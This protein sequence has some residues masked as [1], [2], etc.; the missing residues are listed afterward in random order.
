MKRRN[1]QFKGKAC[2]RGLARSSRAVWGSPSAAMQDR[3]PPSSKRSTSKA[4]VGCSGEL[5]RAGSQNS[6][7]LAILS[8]ETMST[9]MATICGFTCQGKEGA[10]MCW[11]PM[12]RETPSRTRS[13]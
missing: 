3:L 8:L 4:M 10:W 1:A 9:H 11:L 12:K 7:A 6:R 2:M 13:T 5:D